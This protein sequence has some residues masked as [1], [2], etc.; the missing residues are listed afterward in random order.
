MLGSPVVNMT[1][2][3]DSPELRDPTRAATTK[4]WTPPTPEVLESYRPRPVVQREETP[5]EQ[6][7]R[8]AYECGVSGLEPLVLRIIELEKLVGEL[9]K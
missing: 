4:K 9:K 8:I 3:A 7:R 2:P 5:Q 6:A 1:M